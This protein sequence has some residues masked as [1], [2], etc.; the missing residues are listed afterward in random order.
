MTKIKL[1]PCPFCGGSGTLIVVPP[2]THKIATWIPDS[3]GS[4]FIECD[5][6]TC[7]ISA[8]SEKMAIDTWNRRA[9][10]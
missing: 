7:A 2:H 3:K 5:K 4:A 8:D 6:C 1:L 9:E 10:K